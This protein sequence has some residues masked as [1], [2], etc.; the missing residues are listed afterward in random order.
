VTTPNLFI[1]GPP[2]SGTTSLI[3]WLAMHPQI[4]RPDLKEPMFHAVDLATP[5][6]VHDRDAYLAMYEGLGEAAFAVDATPWYLYS[7]EAAASI[8]AM[9]PDAHVIVHLRNPVEVLSSLHARHLIVGLEP[10]PDFERAVFGGPQQED[11]AEFRRCLDYLAVGRFGEQSLRFTSRFSQEKVHFISTED[12]ARRPREVHLELLGSLG[13]EPLPLDSYERYNEAQTVR[14][15]AWS[16]ATA[17]VAGSRNSSRARR[18]IAL[19]M[20][21][22]VA[23][24]GREELSPAVAQRI[25][26]ELADDIT[27]LAE[28]SGHDLSHWLAD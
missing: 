8:Q 7:S 20:A 17:K 4:A 10:E 16:W 23:T 12:M 26:K 21:L 19:R 6:R 9:A 22:R 5:H 27:L 1:V 15:R 11:A 3:E 2:R 28:L 14:S 24:P 18:A 13:L 25:T